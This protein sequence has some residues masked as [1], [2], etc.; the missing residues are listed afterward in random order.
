MTYAQVASRRGDRSAARLESD[1]DVVTTYNI[2]GKPMNTDKLKAVLEDIIESA[3]ADII[4]FCKDRDSDDPVW[5]DHET[6]L[7]ARRIRKATAEYIKCR[8]SVD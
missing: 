5:V 1:R 6:L 8:M 2:P 3:E 7:L 4:M